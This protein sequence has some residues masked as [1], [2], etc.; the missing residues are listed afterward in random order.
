LLLVL[1]KVYEGPEK[2][3]RGGV[4]GSQLKFSGR[5]LGLYPKIN[6]MPLYSNS[7]K[8]A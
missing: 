7:A 3:T 2:A 8:T 5:E 1:F 6:P 4:N